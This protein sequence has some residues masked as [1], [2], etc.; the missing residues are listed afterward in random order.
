MFCLVA[1]LSFVILP[2]M[3]WRSHGRTNSEMVH[4]L[5]KNGVIT[6]ERVVQ[7]LQAV[8]RADFVRD[9]GSA[10]LDQPQPIGHA[11]TISA[12]H[13]HGAV[14]D[15]LEHKLQP[16]ARVLDVG[17]GSGY[18]AAAMA[19]MVQPGGKVYGECVGDQQSAALSSHLP[20]HTW[21]LP[22]YMPRQLHPPSP[23]RPL[24]LPRAHPAYPTCRHRAHPAA[25]AVVP[26]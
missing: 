2:A 20:A 19:Q 1:L 8:D 6:K 24:S 5:H 17:S 26:L 15:L 12:P 21:W 4:A 10:Y 23:A 16:G 11:A 22:T 18:L 14:L 7:A 9:K 13:M 25:R 3:A